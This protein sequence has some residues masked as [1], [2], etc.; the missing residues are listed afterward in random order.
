MADYP[1]P[2]SGGTTGR[3][4]MVR[5]SMGAP[6]PTPGP[7]P[8]RRHAIALRLLLPVALAL[9][10][11]E[12]GE[13]SSCRC[14][15]LVWPDDDRYREPDP[16]CPA[17]ACG[18]CDSYGG[19]VNNSGIAM[20]DVDG[21][22]I[23]PTFYTNSDPTCRYSCSGSAQRSS[24]EWS[25]GCWPAQVVSAMRAAPTDLH[26]Q[27]NGCDALIS[28]LWWRARAP[29]DAGAIEVATAALGRFQWLAAVLPADR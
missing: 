7:R 24:D 18:Y 9:S 2:Y 3:Q 19:I 28:G 22:G 29:A 25:F 23:D 10:V 11:A 13:Q 14:R 12:A 5:C 1:G 4:K 27:V 16:N 20:I 8:P 15:G 6:P 21:H 17:G 26:V